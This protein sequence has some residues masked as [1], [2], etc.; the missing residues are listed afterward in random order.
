M[1]FDIPGSATH[2]GNREKDL[3]LSPGR[4]ASY[5]TPRSPGYHGVTF[6]CVAETRP[7]LWCNDEDGRS[8]A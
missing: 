8:H 6:I 3:A 5:S 1:N 7:I 2:D 4:W